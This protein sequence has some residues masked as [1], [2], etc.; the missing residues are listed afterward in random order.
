MANETFRKPK[1]FPMPQKRFGGGVVPNTL[2]NKSNARMENMGG[3]IK[4][5]RVM[6]ADG[7]IDF[8]LR[9]DS[10]PLAVVHEREKTYTSQSKQEII[11]SRDGCFFMY[12]PSSNQEV[13]EATGSPNFASVSPENYM[14]GVNKHGVFNYLNSNLTLIAEGRNITPN[15][16]LDGLKY[17]PYSQEYAYSNI[18]FFESQRGLSSLEVDKGAFNG[19]PGVI[20]PYLNSGQVA[21]IANKNSKITWLYQDPVTKFPIHISFSVRDHETASVSFKLFGDL[22]N[23]SEGDFVF[24]DYKIKFGELFH[25]S[26]LG[27]VCAK[28]KNKYSIEEFKFFGAYLTNFVMHDVHADGTRALFSFTGEY[29]SFGIFEVS[30]SGSFGYF[31]KRGDYIRKST[32]KFEVRPK[33]SFSS[34]MGGEL[35]CLRY[36]IED[37]TISY[38]GVETPFGHNKNPSRF[39]RSISYRTYL[40]GVKYDSMEAGNYEI[41]TTYVTYSNTSIIDSGMGLSGFVPPVSSKIKKNIVHDDKQYLMNIV[42]NTAI[43]GGLFVLVKQTTSGNITLKAPNFDKCNN[44]FK[45]QEKVLTAYSGKFRQESSVKY[46]SVTAKYQPYFSQVNISS[47]TWKTERF[48]FPPYFICDYPYSAIIPIVKTYG[49]P[50]KIE[51]A[52][53][54]SGSISMDDSSGSIS[55]DATVTLN[56]IDMK[57]CE[58]YQDFKKWATYDSTGTY[59]INYS[60]DLKELPV[61]AFGVQVKI[62]G[63]VVFS[64]IDSVIDEVIMSGTVVAH[65][66]E[67]GC[68]MYAYGTWP[69]YEDLE[70]YIELTVGGGIQI[71]A[72][73]FSTKKSQYEE[74]SDP[75]SILPP[76][77]SSMFSYESK[78]PF[79]VCQTKMERSIFPIDRKRSYEW[80]SVHLEEKPELGTMNTTRAGI[81][82]D[83]DYGKLTVDN[84]EMKIVQHVDTKGGTIWL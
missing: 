78:D 4:H 11:F 82:N 36:N 54:N 57:T 2:A 24:F 5:K 3:G 28:N 62:N 37:E 40:L 48:D 52:L 76:E 30:V 31:N 45:I 35:D 12:K 32:I 13:L 72:P 25:L 42:N 34:F 7:H 77:W 73:I 17:T 26:D 61:D 27:L 14:W 9:G 10:C 50:E 18:I 70:Q 81:C 65:E 84:M 33:K 46:H 51:G 15:Q 8:R 74:M 66:W 63:N 39:S 49:G 47:S 67:R 69:L 53:Q 19:D 21:N 64:K 43:F 1:L 44:L 80:I 56:R 83:V 16:I 29:D 59:D 71:T 6:T 68:Y 20:D 38:E 60:L 41:C 22:S 23:I 58:P 75:V 55:V 79:M